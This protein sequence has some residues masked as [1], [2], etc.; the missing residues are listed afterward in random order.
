MRA[1]R[2]HGWGE[3]PR[4]EEVAEPVREDGQ[5]LVE[6]QAAALSHLDLTVAS[7]TFDLRPELPYTGGVEG[8]GIVLA[9]D[10]LAPGTQVM[11]RGG[12]LGLLRDGTWQE[13]VAI[14]R[15]A[16]TLLEQPLPAAVAATFFVP[17]TTAAVVLRD[18]AR[19]GTEECV[20]VIG[21]AGAVGA[22]VAQQ[23]ARAGAEVVG[24][25]GRADQL[26]DVPSGVQP[27]TLD[28]DRVAAWTTERPF[29][30]IVDTLGGPELPQRTTWVRPGGRAVVVGY[31]AGTS[32][33]LDLPNWLLNDVALLPVNMI[34]QERRAR[35]VMP[36]LVRRLASEELS[37]AVETVTID[38]V[39]SALARLRD[40][41]VRGRA[42][43]VF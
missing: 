43:V 20:A 28:D 12:G 33:V 35:E 19:L 38:E 27:V 25:V 18:V 21:A 8:S 2:T 36:D 32:A 40:G 14:P 23:A 42:A 4:V 6:V 34:R 41:R 16:V 3:L 37:V 10:D 31:V 9:A 7:G 5:V 1:L 29:S 39:P 15:K 24:L 11:L 17:T 13:R 26:Q 30:L 22:A